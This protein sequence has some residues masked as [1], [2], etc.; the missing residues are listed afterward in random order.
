MHA[1]AGKTLR[2]DLG[3]QRVREEP[4]DPAAARAFIGG[5]GLATKM[6]YD[7]VNPKVEPLAGA[8]VL[9]R[10]PRGRRA[11]VAAEFHTGEAGALLEATSW[12]LR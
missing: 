12:P 10:Y 9:D 8:T 11:S 2:V 3:R 5:R 4:I 7:E 6:I 1:Y